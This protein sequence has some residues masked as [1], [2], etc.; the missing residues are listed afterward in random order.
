M[1]RPLPFA[2]PIYVTRPIAPPL[3][4][5]AALLESVWSTRW[6]TNNG[7]LH[8]ALEGALAEF[9][10]TPN[11]SLFTNGTIALIVACQ[12]LELTGEV[13][14]TPFT[15]PA[16]PHVL[17]WNKL[18]PVFADVDTETMNIDPDR[19]EAL[20]S[21]RTSAILAVHVYGTPCAVE[22]IEA[23]ARRHGLRVIYDAAHAFATK[24]SGTPICAYG[25]VT[26][27]SFH[28]TKLFHTAEGGAL[29]AR[30]PQVKAKI[31]L[32]KNFGIRNETEIAMPGINGK[33]SELHAALGLV[34]LRHYQS[35]WT[36]RARV[37]ACYDRELAE[38]AGLRRARPAPD[39][40]ASLQYY[41]VRIDRAHAGRSRDEVHEHLKEFNIFTRRYFYPLC[42]DYDC[43]RHLPSADRARLPVA[44]RAADE[45]LAL[46]FFGELTDDD[47][48]RLCEAIR[49]VLVH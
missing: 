49:Y 16:T 38:V 27:L 43:Y 13:I 25:D 1:N 32:L 35:E 30:D 21:P 2:A 18:T 26:M 34:N 46:P 8:Q 37:A 39:V 24:I 7:T 4:E 6:F 22:P 10:R 11:V 15:F 28:A 40:H 9:L 23:I 19:I 42:S 29:I 36:H 48:S 17:H 47:V 20:I 3:A 12:A 44:R 33:M 14:T 31:D 41:V 45:V 5:Y